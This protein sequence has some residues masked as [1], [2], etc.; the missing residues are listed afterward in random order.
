MV[1]WYDGL[2]GG[3]LAGL[4]VALFYVIVS[5]AW[6]HDMTV[7]EFFANIASGILHGPHLAKNIWAILF[8]VSLHFLVAAVFGIIYAFVAQRVR[9]MW[10]APFSVMWGLLYGLFVWFVISDVLVPLLGITSTLPLWEGLV[11]DTIFYGI[12]LSEYTTV[13]YRSKALAA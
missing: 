3:L 11:A 12:V 2:F 9:S 5:V 13:V 8:G 7:A 4:T 6:L 10:Q 1:R